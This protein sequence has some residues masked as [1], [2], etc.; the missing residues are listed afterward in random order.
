MRDNSGIITFRSVLIGALFVIFFAFVTVYFENQ[1]GLVL[2][3]TQIA[4]APFV[5]LFLLVLL[6][7]P[8][9]RLVRVIR[10]FTF[11]E[12]MLVFIMGSVSAGISTFGMA[13]QVVPVVG[14]LFNQHWN[15]VQSEWRTTVEPFMDE[16]FFVSEPG[17]QEAAGEYR[18]AQL[19]LERLQET[20]DQARV[21]GKARNLY[22]ERKRR[23]ESLGDV[24]QT[25]RIDARQAMERAR[26]ALEEAQIEWQ[27]IKGKYDDVPSLET[28]RDT[29]PGLVARQKEVVAEMEEEVSALEEAAFER[30]ET[31]R[32]G[33]PETIRTFP[34]IIK[35]PDET[36]RSYFSRLRRVKGGLAAHDALEKAR[37]TLR[38]DASGKAVLDPLDEAVEKLT[39]LM[40]QEELQTRKD[41]LTN[42][43]DALNETIRET[44]AALKELRSKRRSAKAEDFGAL[45]RDI[46]R[47]GKKVDRLKEERESLAK[48]LE[49]I[50]RELAVTDRVAETVEDL[51]A[52]RSAIAAGNA[53]AA[54]ERK[55]HAGEIDRLLGRFRTFDATLR[56][57]FLGN[58]PWR[59]WLRPLLLW[60]VLII[61]TYI[62]LM[63][64]NVL[65]FRQWAKNERLIYPLAELPE[66]LAGSAP[67]DDKA[68]ERVPSVFRNGLFWTGALIAM[69]VLGWNMMCALKLLPNINPLDL[70][71]SWTGFIQGTALKGLI[72]EARSP[73]FFTLIGLS[74]LI[75]ANISFSLWFF[76]LLY[77]GQLLLLVGIGLGVN[78]NS[79]GTEWWYTF[80]FR[81]AEGAG[82]LMVFAALVLY[83]CRRYL[84]AGFRPASVRHLDVG[85]QRELRISS[86][87]FVF[88]SVGIILMLWQGLGANI[89]YTIFSYFVILMITI[90]LIRAVA[91]GGILGFQAWCSPFHI[92]RS[93]AGMDKAWTAP[94]LFAPIM[95]Y[96]SILFLD[97]KTFI[98]PAMANSLKIREDAGMSRGK[99]HFAVWLSILLA[100]AT[101]LVAHLLFTYDVG[102]DGMHGWFY[103]H[104]PRGLFEKISDIVKAPPVDEA[105]GRWWLL[106]G[107]IVMAALL[108]FRQ[109]VFW[110]PHPLGMIM[111]VNP[112]MRAYWFSILLG[113]VAKS[114]ITKYGNKDT[115]NSARKF[116][117]GLI[118]GELVMV[119][120]ALIVSYATG[121]NLYMITLNR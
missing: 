91:E 87:L 83:K 85:E 117:V 20:M 59:V 100:M 16:A 66:L 15:N 42:Q 77:W 75:P 118:V 64:F 73:I 9:C 69:F 89:L 70:N 11:A 67:D 50:Q 5:L 114:L 74:F 23:Y 28:V 51:K 21:V 108:Y 60:S 90:A 24:E 34:G 31:F 61:L 112:L 106:F 107:A 44:A 47:T 13:S 88:G 76:H 22:L 84:L 8:V 19:K 81:T 63:S 78:A 102:A 80:N 65:I 116:F 99:F 33:L 120:L 111:L 119:A 41:T 121:E 53:L 56:A 71:N 46:K 54:P 52:L 94:S 104:F 110:L 27:Q 1:K 45:D 26:A 72:P 39:P 48:S 3:A 95:V 79:F 97:L 17:I 103:T 58:V 25:V 35:M 6:I 92:I 113:W 4:P 10:P 105:G 98:A 12:I 96:Y 49:H 55:H 14:S 37:D 30:V 7:N 2:T 36:Y 40:S 82:A 68:A 38:G 86:L 109:T 93:V 32:R 101:A 29:Y 62:V 115:Y 43:R 18:G 57:F